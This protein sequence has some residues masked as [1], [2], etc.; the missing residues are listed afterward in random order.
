MLLFIYGVQIFQVFMK[1]WHKAG[2][3]N[4]YVI[5]QVK[6]FLIMLVFKMV[7]VKWFNTCRSAVE[8]MEDSPC[9]GYHFAC[10]LKNPSEVEIR[11]CFVLIKESICFLR[12][13]LFVSFKGRFLS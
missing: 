6:I 7:H 5:S 13:K 9:I 8:V 1:S 12:S 10:F 3:L 2:F 11:K 4:R